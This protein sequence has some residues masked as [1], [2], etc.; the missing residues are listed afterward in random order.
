MSPTPSIRILLVED[1]PGDAFLVEELLSEVE[2]LSLSVRRAGRV[3][4]ALEALANARF[5]AVLLDLSLPDAHGL[6]A[7]HRLRAALPEVTIVVLSGLNDEQTALQAVRE[8]AQDYLV[9]GRV[10]GEAIARALRHSLERSRI[11]L[12][13]EHQRRSLEAQMSLAIE[14]AG[15]GLWE[16]D[17]VKGKPRWSEEQARL[18]GLEPPQEGEPIATKL[19][20]L[21]RAVHPDD[22][23]RLKSKVRQVLEAGELYE[24]EFRVV[25]SG[26]QERWLAVRGRVYRDRSG[27]PTRMAGITLDTTQRRLAEE[28]LRQS[29]ARLREINQAQ[30]R[31]VADAAHELRAPLTAIQGNLEL[32]HRYPEMSPQ[33]R[34]DSV[35]QALQEARRLGRLVADMLALAR[36]DAGHRLKRESIE[37]DRVLLEAFESACHL[38]QQHH[39]THE[40]EP[41]R[42]VGDRDY[43]KQL[44]LILL[45]NALKYTPPGGKVHLALLH[46]GGH[47][48]LRVS[49]TGN[50]IAPQD[51]PH[52]FE[53]FYRADQS[54]RRDPGGSGLGLSIAKWIVEQHGGKI[55]LESE[56]GKGTT[57]IVWLP[58]SAGHSAP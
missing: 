31:F 15:I 1:N 58:L 46:Q 23:K 24:D 38:S 20:A 39:L 36:G 17:L 3:A 48:E 32:L 33:D 11:Q 52:V 30:Q 34:M 43:L 13:L 29:E 42:L 28:A 5:D 21:L 45:D 49:D 18:L 44:A 25:L 4:E 16:W 50:G 12:E 27:R 7:V 51:L 54:R 26:G 2:G 41:V 14:A 10:D 19:R 22:R 53:R 9:K 8:G 55:R 37:L 57:A 47:A 56:L 40:L 35:V 6:E